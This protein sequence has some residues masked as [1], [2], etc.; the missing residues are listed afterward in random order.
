MG[1]RC[2]CHNSRS[3]IGV[4]IL[5]ASR[6]R[7]H[8]LRQTPQCNR[9][10]HDVSVMQIRTDVVTFVGEELRV[11]SR[12]AKRCSRARHGTCVSD[13]KAVIKQNNANML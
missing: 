4:S 1:V 5:H 8:T 3:S 7:D 12:R 10:L 11:L 2:S 6:R 9:K 13:N